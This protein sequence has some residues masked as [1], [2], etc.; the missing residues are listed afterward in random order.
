MR[1]IPASDIADALTFADLVEALRAAFRSGVI[2]PL[3]HGHD[4]S[5]PDQADATL[6]VLPAWSD[7]D[8][9]GHSERGYVGVKI[10]TVFP[11]NADRDR[12]SVSGVYLLLSGR[13]G[14][15]L[16]FIDGQALTAWRTAATSALASSYLSRPDA[17]RLLMVGAG[18]LAPRLVEAHAA[19][20]PIREVLIWNRSPDRAR[21]LARA[22]AGHAFRAS[23]TEDL[24]GAVRG[25]DIISCA[26]LA[27]GPLIEGTWLAP[28]SHL[29]LVGS[30]RADMR[31]A[32][33]ETIGRARLFV[34]DRRAALADAGEIVQP[35]A[36][37]LIGE[38]DIAADLAELT[39]GDRAGRRFH[40]QITLFKAAGSGLADFAAAAHVFARV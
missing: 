12:P 15:P 10:T 3:R 33:D 29:D 40:D 17:G 11:G 22:M 16:A 5:L 39:R 20:R 21:R 26:T 1:I 27:T 14:E 25:A 2:A 6:R 24:E 7:F 34:D 8:R 4:V 32:D 37:G 28:G 35:L 23:A 30:F 9:Q 19:V 18:T 31:E 13:T 38:S 36:S